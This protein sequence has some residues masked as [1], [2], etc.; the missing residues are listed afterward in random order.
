M[1]L[2]YLMSNSGVLLASLKDTRASFPLL[3]TL[4][5][6]TVV[7]VRGIRALVHGAAA[8]PIGRSISTFC[9]ETPGSPG[10]H[11]ERLSHCQR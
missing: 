10:T 9:K 7:A 6:V 1:P 8:V 4:C 11:P 2:R 3:T 5:H